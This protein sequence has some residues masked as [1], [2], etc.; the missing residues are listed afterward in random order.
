MVQIG[1]INV[2]TLHLVLLHFGF[3]LECCGVGPLFFPLDSNLATLVF[4]C[5]FGSYLKTSEDVF[6]F[7]PHLGD[8]KCLRKFGG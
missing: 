7:T 2:T 4:D 5:L 6:F 1:V 8:R 3:P